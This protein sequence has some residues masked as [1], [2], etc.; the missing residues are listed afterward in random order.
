M[1]K[2][3]RQIKGRPWGTL[4]S[5][6]SLCRRSVLLHSSIATPVPIISVPRAFFNR[7]FIIHFV[8]TA[9]IPKGAIYPK[10][11]ESVSVTYAVWGNFILRRFLFVL[12]GNVREWRGLYRSALPPGA[13]S[14]RT[15]LN[16]VEIYRGKFAQPAV[17]NKKRYF[18]FPTSLHNQ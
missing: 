5:P 16:V 6:T 8:Y 2:A 10:T 1:I 7:P 18:L 12:A 15:I 13:Y 14:A 4:T 11:R 17:S 9:A 3:S